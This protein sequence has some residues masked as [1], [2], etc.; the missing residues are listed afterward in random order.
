MVRKCRQE[1]F[2]VLMWLRE[3]SLIRDLLAKAL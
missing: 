1:R 3:A 2:I